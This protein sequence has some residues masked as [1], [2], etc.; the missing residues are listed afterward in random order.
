MKNAKKYLST[1]LALAVA[2]SSFTACDNGLEDYNKDSF[3]PP[4]DKFNAKIQFVSRLT[5][6]KLAT[7]DADY[8]AINNYMV[9]TLQGKTG[10]WLT[11]LDRVDGNS[12]DKTLQTSLNTQ[13]WTAFAMNRIADKTAYE[14]SMLY[15]NNPST[16]SKGTASGAGCFVTGIAPTMKGVRVERDAEG[17]I[18]S[19]KD[20][21]FPVHFRTVRFENAD[22]IGAFASDGGVLAGLY[23][24][25]MNFLM[26]GTVK[27]DLFGALQTAAQ[28][29]GGYFVERVAQGSAYTIFMLADTRFWGFTGMTS[30]SLGN[31]IE[32]YTVN[33]MW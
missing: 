8:T 3:S 13:R 16:L 10:S 30:E 24:D 23:Y 31:G 32:V 12:L 17:N 2:L 20:V 25:N 29:A 22:Q 26:V 15:F 5:D 7:S 33:V 18:K 6:G 1:A 9:N 21:S 11:V 4:S 19:S 14:G 27:N 28:G